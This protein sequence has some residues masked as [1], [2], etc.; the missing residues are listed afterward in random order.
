MK[1]LLVF[2]LTLA[3]VLAPAALAEAA[4]PF[5]PMGDW[6]ADLGGFTVRL[7]LDGDGAYTLGS[8]V[9]PGEEQRGT[10]EYRDGVIVLDGDE[11]A[12]L[13][14]ATDGPAAG[15]C[16][17]LT[18]GEAVFRRQAPAGY[19]PSDADEAAPLEVFSGY[20]KSAYVSLGGAP[21]PAEAFGDNTDVFIEGTRVALGGDL[22]GDVFVDFNF[23]NGAMTAAMDDLTLTF[24]LQ[25]DDL[26]RLTV[27]QADGALTLYLTSAPYSLDSGD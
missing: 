15:E 20:W 25:R 16:L 23:A 26:L 10:W 3:L 11:T 19:E 4:Q 5:D 18:E 13:S 21:V 1:K 27:D 9:V 24:V 22:F 14:F 6:Y 2:L 12:P 17:V 7:T 8:V